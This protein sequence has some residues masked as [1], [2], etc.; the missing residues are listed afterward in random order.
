MLG[1]LKRRRQMGQRGDTIVEVLIA[2]T[3][4]SMIL[5]GAYVTTNHSLLA[6]RDAQERA[7]G[8]KLVESQLEQLKNVVTTDSSKLSGHLGGFC[9]SDA[10]T[11]QDATD[12]DCAMDASGGPTTAE[13]TYHINITGSSNE[14][15]VTNT[16]ASVTGNGNDT[17]KMVYRVYP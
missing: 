1:R 4:V 11:V 5:G 14:Y 16:W 8:L 15:T 9:L 17:I 10:N 3:V 12:P 13:P 2:I 6:T 7:D